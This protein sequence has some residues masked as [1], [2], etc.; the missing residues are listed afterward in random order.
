MKRLPVCIYIV[1]MLAIVNLNCQNKHDQTTFKNPAQTYESHTESD[2]ANMSD[3]PHDVRR[4]FLGNGYREAQWGMSTKQVSDLLRAKILY[5]DKVI[6]D[7]DIFISYNLGGG[8][9]VTCYFYKN[10]FYRA[11]YS[12]SFKDGDEIAGEAVLHGL[13]DKYGQPRQIG[14]MVNAWTESPLIVYQWDDDSTE[15]RFQMWDPEPLKRAGG[16]YP[17]ST[18]AVS[19]KSK[20]ISIKKESELSELNDK[21]R[22]KSVQEKLKSLKNDF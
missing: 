19:Y 13:T 10:L 8:K 11:E 1:L 12:P 5:H 9:S 22:K 6:T 14:G 21:V 17:S 20:F 4:V 2:S 3:V 16:L 15:I 18:I 7:G